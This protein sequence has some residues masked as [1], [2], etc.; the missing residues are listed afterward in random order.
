[1]RF[2]CLTNTVLLI[3]NTEEIHLKHWNVKSAV[4]RNGIFNLN[5]FMDRNLNHLES[6]I[7]QIIENI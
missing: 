3:I 5:F 1:M 4:G 6:N 2:T 7:F